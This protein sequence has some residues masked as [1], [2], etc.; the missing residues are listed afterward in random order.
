MRTGDD[1]E[2]PRRAQYNHP[3]AIQ[4]TESA[5]A[6]MRDF[7]ARHPGAAGVRFGIR[8]TGCF[9]FGYKIGLAY[10]VAEQVQ[11]FE[12]DGECAVVNAKSLTFAES[13]SIDI[14]R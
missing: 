2:A 13:T 9:G 1:S 3:M 12:L 14:A 10:Y 4:L 5:A 7:I 8:K 11:V 6:R